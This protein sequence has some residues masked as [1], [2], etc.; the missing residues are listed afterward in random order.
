MANTFPVTDTPER[1]LDVR[2]RAQA[3]SARVHVVSAATRGLAGH[4]VV[5][6]AAMVDLGVTLFSDDGKCVSDADVVT[7]VL[8]LM[9]LHG[10]T[11]AQH[12][13]NPHL[14]GNGVINARVASAVG[15]PGWPASGEESI[16]ARDL[17]IVR[18][19]GGRLHVC[20][21]STAGT[22]ELIRAAKAEGLPVTAE[23]TPHH[24]VLT[25]DDG[26]RVGP[27]LKV[28]PPL[29]AP[30]DVSALRV[31]LRDG[32]IDTIGTDHAPHPD[33]A[34]RKPWRDAAFGL[35]AIETALP[36]VAEVLTDADTGE[37]DWDLLT[38]VM[39]RKPASIGGIAETAG[40]PVS[41]GEPATFC[42]VENGG[43]WIV[44]G[45][46]HQSISYNTPFEGRPLTWR[47]RLTVRDGLV[48][49]ASKES[50]IYPQVPL[51]L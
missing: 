33:E 32:T 14:V 15:A 21:V 29:R 3:S 28:N 19:T 26:V 51:S 13:Q 41:I 22:I 46:E 4:D 12:A 31:A 42:V 10:R 48:T 50:P 45:R 8:R 40:R 34:K 20:H 17:T 2:R 11:F 49:Y 47:V 36:I 38:R 1:V 30:A 44:R 43:P 5:D 18:K 24:L 27:A 39:S 35:T 23:V 9:K 25:N 16:V 7:E 37:V 6:V